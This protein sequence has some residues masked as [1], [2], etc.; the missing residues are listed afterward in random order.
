MWFS[1]RYTFSRGRSCVPMTFLRIRSCTRCRVWFFELILS[2]E[3]LVVRCSLFVVR[4]PLHL[5]RS[6]KDEPRKALLSSCFSNLLLQPFA[7]VAHALVL[8]RIGRT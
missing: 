2:I 1:D 7:G 5:P 4:K 8:I 3:T 6:A